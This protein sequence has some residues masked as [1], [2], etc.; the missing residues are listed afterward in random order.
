MIF[1][2]HETS[3][4]QQQNPID[5][6]FRIAC[7]LAAL[8]WAGIFQRHVFVFNCAVVPEG[9]FANGQSLASTRCRLTHKQL[10]RS[11]SYVPYLNICMH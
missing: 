11:T 7:Y 10:V 6:L 3:I 9:E 8:V 2:R 5:A 1:V 4:I